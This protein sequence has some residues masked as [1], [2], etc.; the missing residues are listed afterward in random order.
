MNYHDV[1][2]R[3]INN[4]YENKIKIFKEIDSIANV[5]ICLFYL[6]RNFKKS[7]IMYPCWITHF[8]SGRFSFVFKLT[9]PRLE[10]M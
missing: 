1:P 7:N 10:K 5:Q 8:Y 2:S 4:F 6:L 9:Y 3:V